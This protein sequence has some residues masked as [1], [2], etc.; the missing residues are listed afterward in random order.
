MAH[1]DIREA[2]QHLEEG[3]LV[4]HP[5]EAVYGIGGGLEAGPLSRLRAFKGRGGGGF[6]VLIPSLD[7]CAPL[8]RDG[9]HRIAAEFWPGPVTLILD[10]PDDVFAPDA[11]ASDGS[12][13][14]RIPG[15]DVA[16]ALVEAYG[17]PMTSTSANRPGEAPATSLS[18][19]WDAV[20][21]FDA[22][23][24]GLDGGD[25]SG[26]GASTLVD[27]RGRLPRIL[28]RGALV[29]D[30]EEALRSLREVG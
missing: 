24:F 3:G 8:F 18:Q 12:V 22:A 30:V 28:R 1:A 23:M 5:T 16:R 7:L 17:K 25:L 19:A 15:N 20:S 14:V 10:D 26:L 27:T 13:A 2:V 4:L 9:A 21:G 11:K 29:E 6:V